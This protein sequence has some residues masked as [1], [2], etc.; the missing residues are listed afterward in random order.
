[1]DDDAAPGRPSLPDALFRT[2]AEHVPVGIAYADS[3][4]TIVYAN[5]RWCELAGFRGELP[6]DAKTML[7]L[8][9][10][11]DRAIVLEVFS[12]SAIGTG[13]VSERVRVSRDGDS[14]QHVTISVR[15][16]PGD[17]GRI[18]GYAVGLSDV[19]EVAHALEEVR[20][21]EARFRLLTSALPVGVFRT[22]RNGDL[23]WANDRMSEISGYDVSETK[24]M[25]VFGFTHTEDQDLVY[26]RAQEA[27]LRRTPLESTHRFVSRDG[28]VRWVMARASAIYDD[29]GHILE[30]VGTIEDVTELRMVSEGY[31]HRAHHDPLTELPNRASIEE[32]IAT[33]CAK[34]PGRADIGIV[35]IDLDRFKS[36]ND[37]HG[38]QAGD[39]VL[40]VVG[41]RLSRVIRS[42][43]VVGRYGGDEFVVVCPGVTD[44]GVVDRV[45]HRVQATI[46]ETPIVVGEHS[47]DVGASVGTAI[48]PGETSPDAFLHA[49][50]VAMYEA[51]R[52]R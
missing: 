35:F 27:L 19:S 6:T 22:D 51:K 45:A 37:T 52:N 49:A 15:T 23:F 42:E 32:M 31:A 40:R 38:H 44:P 41:Q 8:I 39:E 24:G 2:L 25:S 3:T 12:R 17:D 48:G 16:I 13:E 46:A 21:S 18:T 47:F 34:T 30:H 9:H 10:E 36:V 14:V 28:T 5:E 20:R 43:D 1:M 50:D 7:G 4:G 29:G 33:L 11:D 26:H